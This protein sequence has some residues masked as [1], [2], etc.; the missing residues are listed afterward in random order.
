M[1]LDTQTGYYYYGARYYDPGTSIFLSVDPLAEDYPNWTPYHYVHNN[2]INLV[3]PT[4][5][6]AQNP[7]EGDPVKQPQKVLNIK[8]YGEDRSLYYDG[9]AFSFGTGGYKFYSDS[10]TRGDLSLLKG[11]SG[12]GESIDADAAFNLASYAKA[13]GSGSM[14]KTFKEGVQFIGNL[15][16]LF[17][18]GK[19]IKD[20][21]EKAI[22]SDTPKSSS[23]AKVTKQ[24]NL[25]EKVTVSRS[26]YSI[27]KG[28]AYN[29][30]RVH[31]AV[32]DTV[33]NGGNKDFVKQLD[34]RDSIRVNSKIR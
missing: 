3:D 8:F 27:V 25:S 21:I 6:S 10:A 28:D 17:S 31:K 16:D 1:L 14:Y 9:E 22:G 26:V 30:D 2:P 33:I 11:N 24:E 15:I 29:K 7:G 23:S 12:E 18:K 4:G 32:K 34:K 20:G 19:D 5:M 13:F